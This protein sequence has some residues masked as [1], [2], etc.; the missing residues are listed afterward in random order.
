MTQGATDPHAILAA[1]PEHPVW[2]LPSAGQVA[3]L[4]AKGP[5]GVAYLQKLFEQRRAR[6]ALEQADPF[7]HGVRLSSWERADA[8]LIER[9]QC[10]ELLILGGNR[11]AKTEWAARKVVEVLASKENAEAWCFQTTEKNSILMQQPRVWH[12]LLPE[13][14]AARRGQITAITYKKATG[15]TNNRFVAPNGSLCD[16][17]NYAQDPDTIEGG[18]IDI[19]WCD[20]LV[21]LNWLETLRYRLITRDGILIVTFTPIH[22][23]TPTVKAYLDG[24]ITLQ[25]T[26]AELLKDDPDPARRRVPL[27]QQCINP[28]TARVV[29]FHTQENPFNPFERLRRQLQNATRQ[30]I[31]TRAYGVP[32]KAVAGRFPKYNER[33]HVI[34]QRRWELVTKGTWY[35]VV[36]PCNGRNFYMI[37]AC[38]TPDERIIV[39]R[40]WPQPGDYI[41]GIGNP[42]MWAIPDGV[43][44]DGAPGDAQQPFGFGLTRYAEEMRRVEQETSREWGGRKQDDKGEWILIEPAERLMDSRFG[45]APT[46][47]HGET[48]TLIE[49]FEQL[50][51]GPLYFEPTAG[52]ALDEGITL[53]NDALDYN[54]DEP[55]SSQNQ[56]KLY[57]HE[58]CRNLRFALQTWTGQDGKHGACKD[59]IDALR[60]LL[61]ADPQYIED[62]H[63]RALPGQ[64][65]GWEKGTFS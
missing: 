21:P 1:E 43:K 57:I 3:A 35:H 44:H 10:N 45:N 48:S 34:D 28:P 22:G 64:I 17:R 41:P 47:A 59:C 36:D 49:E 58:D 26:E 15:F 12:Y 16:F 7:R 19:C 32:T 62:A 52:V 4:V 38:V 60:Y 20:E 27:V 11:G 31:L 6:M 63:R 18:E 61:L 5:E 13:W 40:E 25:D 56:P 8:Q 50:A 29:Y 53:I 42:G 65:D 54:H 46:L 55:I 23:Y 33:V 9:E 37:W 39:R 2:V 24:A 51:S 14:K 30:E